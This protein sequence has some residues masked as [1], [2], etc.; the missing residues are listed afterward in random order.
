MLEVW[1]SDE[2]SLEF[3]IVTGVYWYKYVGYK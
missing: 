3:A 2:P 1:A